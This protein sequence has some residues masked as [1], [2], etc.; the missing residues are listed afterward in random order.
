V[1]EVTELDLGVLRVDRRHGPSWVAQVFPASRL[2]GAVEGDALIQ[3]TQQRQGVPA[4]R[5]ATPEPVSAPCSLATPTEGR[6]WQMSA[7]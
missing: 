4:E 3:Q 1:S 2:L 5:C 6:H 7:Q